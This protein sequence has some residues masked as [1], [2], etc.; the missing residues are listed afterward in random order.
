MYV[1]DLL[2]PLLDAAAIR[3]L[4]RDQCL[5]I[6]AR[7]PRHVQPH[8]RPIAEY[9]G[10][11]CMGYPA[12]WFTQQACGVT[13]EE[14]RDWLERAPTALFMSLST[15]IADDFLDRDEPVSAEHLMFFYAL[16]LE[17]LRARATRRDEVFER[18]YDEMTGAMDLFVG[19]PHD[20]TGV[21][22][23]GKRIGN[24]FKMIAFELFAAGGP[25]SI[26]A[27]AIVRDAGRFG[28]WCAALD[29]VIDVEQDIRGGQQDSFPIAAV[30]A[31]DPTAADRIRCR[32]TAGVSHWLTSPDLSA[33]TAAHLGE[34]LL[35]IEGE[36]CR[37]SPAL[38]TRL[39][40]IRHRLPELVVSVRRQAHAAYR[41]ASIGVADGV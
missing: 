25:A 33:M 13:D 40:V 39:A 36:A 37:Y 26:H 16:I 17:A 21:G 30:A 22:S 19:R 18:I 31:L 28:E 5:R 24:F 34:R 27:E 3:A 41:A 38:T 9:T 4:V 6:V 32:D 20:G 29:D 12:V 7:L 11:K 23:R 10:G 1:S 14:T 35:V 8:L 15:S 2:E